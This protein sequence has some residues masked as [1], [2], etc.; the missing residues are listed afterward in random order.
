MSKEACAIRIPWVLLAILLLGWGLRVFYLGQLSIWLDEAYTIYTAQQELPSLLR[1][2]AALEH[3]PLYFVL[4][5]AWTWIAGGGSFAWRM[6]SVASGMLGI[7]GTY[8]LARRLVSAPV[9]AVAALLV[10]LSPYHVWYSRDVRMYEL[11]YALA[12]LACALFVGGVQTGSRWAWAGY[13]AVSLA[14]LYTINMMA[15]VFVVQ[16]VY[17]LLYWRRAAGRILGLVSAMSAVGVGYLPWLPVAVMQ[18]LHVGQY[19][20]IQR[21]NLASI[22]G[23]FLNF[24]SAFLF[25]DTPW[26][27][28]LGPWPWSL[29]YLALPVAGVLGV[30]ALVRRKE[31]RAL[32][33]M[34]ALLLVPIATVYV[35]SQVKPI[36][37]DRALI[38]ASGGLVL[39]VSVGCSAPRRVWL[40]RIGQ[41]TLVLVVVT[42]VVS[43]CHLYREGWKEEWNAA[44][45]L[46]ASQVREGDLVLVDSG[47]CQLAFDLYYERYDAG[48]ESHGYPL[49]FE[50]WRT[51][52]Y[53]LSSRW[54]VID[55][56][57]YDRQLAEERLRSLLA[58]SDR[59]W[60][61]VNRPLGGTE[62]QAFLAQWSEGHAETVSLREVTVILYSPESPRAQLT[63]RN[64]L[65]GWLGPNPRE[66]R[67]CF[68]STS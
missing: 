10:A 30:M 68:G 57:H 25:S 7:A 41:A 35:A 20:W 61:I 6:L 23:T 22:R 28:S 49:D 44:A 37:Q 48:I 15:L 8:L 67:V 21:P 39:L 55:F 17:G 54:W 29:V 24:Y 47:L 26:H 62:L 38:A 63:P 59:V 43:L 19:F 11:Y 46:V 56:V 52:V 65:T 16:L 40:R 27:P 1:F 36:Y 45:G 3:P 32:V 33:W 18:L 50:H 51:Q 31:V 42:N 2:V 64:C 4:L 9:A 66:Q 34:G 13:A 5:R 60:L 58:Q 12:M 53:T 14:G